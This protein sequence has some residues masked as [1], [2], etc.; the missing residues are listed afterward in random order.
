MWHANQALIVSTTTI[1]RVRYTPRRLLD[2]GIFLH[3]SVLMD[4]TQTVR[5]TSVICA[6][7]GS[8][9]PAMR[10]SSVARGPRRTPEAPRRRIAAVLLGSRDRMDSRARRVCQG[11]SSRQWDPR[12]A[13]SA[14]RA[15]IA[16][17]VELPIQARV[18]RV[19]P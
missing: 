3:V 12:N 17:R 18:W 14:R 6:M 15:C 16:R 13:L 19:A 10:R 1:S 2:L 8:F 7:R 9:A 5:R 4:T 11:R